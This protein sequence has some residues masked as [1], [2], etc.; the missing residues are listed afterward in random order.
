MQANW[1][2]GANLYNKG[3][4]FCNKSFKGIVVFELQRQ[5]KVVRQ[6]D[7][8]VDCHSEARGIFLRK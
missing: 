4:K 5:M 7:A 8:E 3:Y 6:H 1:F 2:V